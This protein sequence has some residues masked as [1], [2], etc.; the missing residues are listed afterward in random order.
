METQLQHDLSWQ[1]LLGIYAQ[2]YI[3]CKQLDSL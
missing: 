1:K 2:A 3:V